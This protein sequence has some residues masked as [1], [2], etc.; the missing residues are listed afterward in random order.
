[1]E[2]QALTTTDGAPGAASAPPATREGP[3][4]WMQ[5]LA[6][7]HWLWA[8]LAYTLLTAII[9]FPLVFHLG[10][11]VIGPIAK[12]DDDWYIW[13]LWAFRQSVLGGHDPSYSHLL[14]SLYP[15]VQIFAAST[16]NGLMG[17]VLQTFMSPL[18]TYNVL[19]L[20]SFVL[21]GFTMYL[22]ATE[23]IQNRLA[24]FAAGFVFTF[25]TYHF[26]RA[27]GHL[28]LA[29]VQWLPLMVWRVFVFYR[30]P[31]VL[32][33]IWMGIA[34]ALVPLSDIYLAAYFLVPFVLLFVA[35]KLVTDR[36]WFTRPRHL[37]L[38]GLAMVIAVALTLPWLYSSLH[39]D[40]SLQ[41]EI[42]DKTL[43]G[44]KGLS[45]D[46]L[47][48]VVPSPFS[49]IF[50]S[51]TTKLYAHMAPPF[52]LSVEE[53]NY[54]G[55]INLAAGLGVLAFLGI[56][57]RRV[58]FWVVVGVC[59]FLL[60][61]GPVLHV[62]GHLQIPLPFYGV[63]YNWPV[64]SNLRAPTRIAPLVMLPLAMLVAF[65]VAA[66]YKR[67]VT[68]R[69][70]RVVFLALTVAAMALSLGEHTLYAFPYPTSVIPLPP[71]YAQ[72]AA[73]PVPGAVLD[74]PVD[75]R[76]A[77][78]YYQTIHHRLLIGGYV[79]RI[80]DAMARTIEN[81]PYLSLF[82][83]THSALAHDPNTPSDVGL[84]DIYPLQETLLQGLQ[85]VHVR[86]VLLHTDVS[87]QPVYPWMVDFL[88]QSLGAPIFANAADALMVWRIEPS[89]TTPNV[90]RFA[91]GSGWV[92]GTG[93]DGHN[94]YRVAEQDAQL[95]I[96]APQA[97]THDL[98]MRVRPDFKG[99]TM[100]VSLNGNTV[101]TVV[102]SQVGVF[103][104][105][106]LGNIALNAGN[107]LLQIHSVNGCTV[108]SDIDPQSTDTRC[109]SFDV[110][111]VA[112]SGVAAGTGN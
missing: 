4:D 95:T 2:E 32:N 110:A 62:A 15:S 58:V 36:R 71:V 89:G 7:S 6:R 52:G 25:T 40:P 79:E 81:I 13:Y 10:D 18:A 29:A 33:A 21:S 69:R 39:V 57:T 42:A 59:G 93:I 74:L 22:L 73:D 20:L 82:Y 94:L 104:T 53:A 87:Y 34:V 19:M 96:Q 50:G 11:R 99:R 48:Y 64:L 98:T 90:Y 75:P 101:G 35:G 76:G 85:A 92:P 106:D 46:A 80:S 17:I 47:S 108:E 56:R 26:A 67:Y 37:L 107:N 55:W 72:M 43:T 84:R 63:I 38:A 100:V 5:R 30:R 66:L 49:P 60:S 44:I 65:S 1:M 97:G 9:T 51:V 31:T 111:Q 105:V 86:Y 28:D 109:R 16:L 68:R 91:L 77:D 54:L 27:T 12:G 3:R 45:A 70:A 78:E 24:C 23:F 112:L 41:A 103:Q 88:N 83:S 8:L 61:L 102:L 14:F